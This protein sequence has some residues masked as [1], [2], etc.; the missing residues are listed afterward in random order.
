M[1]IAAQISQRH[2]DEL[3]ASA[4]P[5]EIAVEAGLRSIGHEEAYD[6]GFRHPSGNGAQLSGWFIPYLDPRTGEP[7]PRFGRVK[8]DHQSNGCKYL[9][10]VAEKPRLYFTPGTTIEDL[11]NPTLQLFIV[12]GEKKGLALLAWARRYGV[13]CVIVATGGCFSWMQD[14]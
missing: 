4:I 7:S 9:S 10:P 11:K 14:K 8:L 1:S 3:R 2:L 13:R 5:P 12:E 6:R